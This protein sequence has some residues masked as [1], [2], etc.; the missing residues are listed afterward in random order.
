MLDNKFLLRNL[1]PHPVYSHNE[2]YMIFSAYK[3]IQPL[4][5]NYLIQSQ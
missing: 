5:K 3:D 2:G 1:L 4:N